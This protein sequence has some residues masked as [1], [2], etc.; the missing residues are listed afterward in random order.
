MFTTGFKFHFTFKVVKQRMFPLLE[1]TQEDN[2]KTFLV[3]LLFSYDILRYRV[4]SLTSEL[5]NEFQNEKSAT[6]KGEIL[7]YF[8]YQIS[9]SLTLYFIAD[10]EL[11]T[12]NDFSPTSESLIRFLLDYKAYFNRINILNRT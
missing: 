11:R 7:K 8:P 10:N 12:K 4:N 1:C 9:K 3:P 6:S 2:Q 5:S